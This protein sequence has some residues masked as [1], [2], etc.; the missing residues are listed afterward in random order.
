MQ[1]DMQYIKAIPEKMSNGASL[2]EISTVE[3]K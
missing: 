2:F 1:N 3:Q